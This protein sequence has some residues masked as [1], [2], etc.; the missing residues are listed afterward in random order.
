RGPLVGVRTA[1]RV[2]YGAG[3]LLPGGAAIMV[4]IRSVGTGRDVVLE[5]QGVRPDVGVDLP[6]AE[7]D[8]GVDAQL[9]RAVQLTVQRVAAL[10]PAS[11]R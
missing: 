2:G 7:L 6:T 9:Q 5:K 1:G 11:G 4:T 8:R 3:F 10:Q